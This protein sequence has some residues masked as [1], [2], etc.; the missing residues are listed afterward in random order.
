MKYILALLVYHISEKL[1]PARPLELFIVNK[2]EM[3][4]D[5]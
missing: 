1:T 2:V 5:I 4:Y 3:M